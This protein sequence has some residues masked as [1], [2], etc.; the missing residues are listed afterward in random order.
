MPSGGRLFFTHDPE[1]ALA[2]VVLDARGRYTPTEPL[3]VPIDLAA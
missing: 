3:S 2:R 1:V